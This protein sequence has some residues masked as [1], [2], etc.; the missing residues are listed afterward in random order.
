[1]MQIDPSLFIH[2]P[3]LVLV[4]EDDKTT[5]TMLETIFDRAGFQ[6]E[7]A[8][9][10]ISA[11]EKAK[12]MMPDLIVLDIMMPRMDGFDVLRELRDNP[13]TKNI[14]TIIV[15]AMAKQPAD[16]ERGLNLGA[17]DF[18]YKPFNPHE[19]IARA[20]S[21]MRNRKLEDELER[22]SKQMETLLRVSDTFSQNLNVGDLLDLIP[23][24]ALDLLPGAAGAIYVLGDDGRVQERRIHQRDKLGKDNP[25]FDTAIA[26]PALLWLEGY[27][28]RR[29]AEDAP[30]IPQ[31]SHGMVSAIQQGDHTLGVLLLVSQETY[32][33]RQLRLFEGIGNQAALALRNAQL[34]DIQTRHALE[35][36]DRVRE[37]TRE[38]EE[39]Q[40]LL[41]RQEKLASI[42]HL[43]AS[44]A[45]EINNPLMPIRN[46]LDDHLEEIDAANVQYDRK[47]MMLIQESLERIRRIVSRLLDFTGKRNEG[48]ALIDVGSVL[49]GVIDLNRKFFSTG[50][51]T[52]EADIPRLTPIYGS[53][54]QLE[55]VF[56]NLTLNAQAAM[57]KGGI[58]AVRARQTPAGIVVEFEDNGTGIAPEHID[59]IFDPFFSTKPNGTGLGLFV[60]YGIIQ[61]HNGE[62][63][64]R[65][66]V[67]E[68]TTFTILLPMHGTGDTQ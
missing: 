49:E 35:L 61:G 24:L 68:G 54:D 60:S 66:K 9:D 19:L 15:T 12:M 43:A 59:R 51:V 3:P 38:L 50:G 64:V 27:N 20:Q 28:A 62:I 26:A 18:L 40:Q 46:L 44:I 52:I 14:P 55:Q 8:F 65:S 2:H 25:L 39:T 37:R 1:M 23:Q 45:H 63:K 30:F 56:M 34:Y 17:D 41:L 13:Q 10:G 16:I 22:R 42:G 58:L 11:L 57:A 6:I 5:S 67:G 21:K 29:W 33:D 32:D 7:T 48:L 4:A 36:E 53:K 47:A 31:F